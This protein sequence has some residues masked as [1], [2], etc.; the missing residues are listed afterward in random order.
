MLKKRKQDTGRTFGITK[1]LSWSSVA[2]IFASGLFMSIVIA[3]Y[4]RDILL[5]KQQEF[6]KLLVENLNQQIYRRFTLPTILGVGYIALEEEEQFKRLDQVVRWSTH[7]LHMQELRVYGHE[8]VVSYSTD[9]SHVGRKDLAGESVRQ[10]LEGKASFQIIS[11]V[12]P[13]WAIFQLGIQPGTVILRT[14]YPLRDE[15]GG[16]RGNKEEKYIMGVLEVFQD[17][18]KDYETVI[19]FQWLIIAT[20]LF[21]CMAMSVIMFMIIRRVDRINA[22][23]QAD[24]ERL[25]RELHQNEKLVSMGRMVASIAHE[26]RNPLGII[27]SSAELLLSRASGQ[28]ALTSKILQA[29]FDEAKR[30]S[31]TVGDF[32]DYARPQQPKQ[33]RVDLANV[34]DQALGFLEGEFKKS[35]VVIVRRFAPGL[36]VLGDKDLLYRAFYNIIINGVQALQGEDNACAKKASMED[37]QPCGTIVIEA[38]HKSDLII[39]RFLDSGPGFDTKQISKMLDPFF[40][41]KDTGT[42]L[43]LAIVNNIVKNH[44]GGMDIDNNPDGGAIVTFTFPSLAA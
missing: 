21:T 19:R 29:I 15:S 13:F 4:A 28:D 31:Q 22:E 34:L 27:R 40:T 7:G 26:I 18:T 30:L 44:Q 32:L 25:E 35:G 1:I 42:G 10:A 23:R 33:D 5:E 14:I 3:N 2:L 6:A 20:T 11:K 39:V 9:V 38:E 36:L 37:A 41:T 8:M 16:L 17:I 43:G 12:S 24:K